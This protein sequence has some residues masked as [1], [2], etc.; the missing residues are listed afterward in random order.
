MSITCLKE[1]GDH[2]WEPWMKNQLPG[3]GDPLFW[4]GAQL[5][6]PMRPWR[7]YAWEINKLAEQVKAPV[8]PFRSQQ[9]WGCRKTDRSGHAEHFGGGFDFILHS[10]G[11]SLN[12]RKANIL[13]DI[14]YGLTPNTGYFVSAK[15]LLHHYACTLYEK[16]A[17]RLGQCG[18]H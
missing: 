1:K 11:M 9:Y 12:V 8:I 18:L 13:P 3:Y 16:D 17:M 15:I 2:L 7:Y 10:I 6:L 4:R 14:D 5:V